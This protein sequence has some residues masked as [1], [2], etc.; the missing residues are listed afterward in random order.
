[1]EVG[2]LLCYSFFSSCMCS[3]ENCFWSAT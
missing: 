3:C 2:L 1:L